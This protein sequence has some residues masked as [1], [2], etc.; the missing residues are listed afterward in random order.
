MLKEMYGISLANKNFKEE[1][2]MNQLVIYVHGKGGSSEE[3]EHYKPLFNE[4]D[5]IGFDYKSQYPW[6]AKNEFSDFYDLHSKGYDSVILI[7]NSIGAFLAMNSLYEK[8]IE[9]A[10]FISPIVNMEKLIT[11]M[12]IWAN[13]TEEELCIKK[14]IPTEFGEI[15][16]W[17]YLCYVKSNQIEWSIPTCI[18]Y[19]EKD[20]LT[21]I[22]TIS[23]F[24]DK[25]D[26]L[27]TVM[28]NGEHWFHTDEQMEFLDNWIKKL[29]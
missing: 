18:L 23:E 7:A 13:V 27:L 6:E 3:S 28:K 14:E 8:R 16:S 10:L 2:L 26:A 21:S 9:K 29:T 17:K 22:E 25:T 20:N 12:M 11:D 24:A 4:S 5:V 19:G 15:L 1:Y